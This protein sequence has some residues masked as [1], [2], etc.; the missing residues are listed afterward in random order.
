[1][2]EFK[3]KIHKTYKFKTFTTDSLIMTG[4]RS[5]Y[6]AKASFKINKGARRVSP[7]ENDEFEEEMDKSRDSQPKAQSVP[8]RMRQA[9]ARKKNFKLK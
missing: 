9:P 7:M 3:Q 5:E 1:M 6:R 4:N 2:G 8:T